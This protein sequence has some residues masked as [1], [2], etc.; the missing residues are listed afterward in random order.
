MKGFKSDDQDADI[1]DKD[2][3]SK[4]SV[5]LY[6]RV[7]KKTVGCEVLTEKNRREE[8]E[9]EQLD[10]RSHKHELFPK[11]W[12]NSLAMRNQESEYP[13]H[14]NH[15]KRREVSRVHEPFEPEGIAID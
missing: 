1:D 4:V 5:G 6:L 7:R 12:L 2:D 14:S 10:S 15:A 11:T 9:E 13:E 8:G 3:H